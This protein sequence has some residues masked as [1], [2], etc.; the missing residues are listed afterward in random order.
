[1]FQRGQT[2][3]NAVPRVSNSNSFHYLPINLLCILKPEQLQS[4]FTG[5]ELT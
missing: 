5:K 2:E 1:M 3:E 4:L